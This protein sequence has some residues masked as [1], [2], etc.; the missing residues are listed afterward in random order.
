ME[1]PVGVMDSV[2]SQRLIDHHCHGVVRRDLSRVD[3]ERLL[4]E[5]D[6]P[7]PWH[8]SLFDTHVGLAIRRYCAPLL[9]LARHASP[10]DY[11]SRRTE[12]GHAEVARRMLSASGID[13][14][15]VDT[16]LTDDDLTTVAELA[17]LAGGR[18]RHVV[19][20]ERVAEQVVRTCTADEYADAFAVTLADAT[21]GA[22]AVKSI[23]AYR[24]GLDLRPDR[25]TPAEVARAAA[26]WRD[27]I[28]NGAG[29]RLTDETLIRH[30]IW[31]GLDGGRPLQLHVGYGDRDADLRRGDPLL[32]TPL[33][34]A[35][36]DAG[37][38]VMLLHTYPFHR[39]AGYLAQVYDHVFVDVGL[40]LHNV[41]PRGRVVL[42]ELLELAPFGSVLFSTDAY[43]LPELYAVGAT[44]FR[45]ALSAVLL[46]GLNAGYWS[47]PDADRF[48]G[49]IC[50]GNAERAYS[51]LP[52]AVSS[53]R[54]PP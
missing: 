2:R 54:P 1:Y 4:C 40:T 32:L 11:L 49:M 31:T 7:G 36:V 38:P 25:P 22:T 39:Q 3:F 23:A 24:C 5:A 12:L 51:L 10:E 42:A 46:T 43:G 26:R 44:M 20:L 33:L 18:G 45:Q 30:G 53:P 8:G 50:V 52:A 27:E 48:A 41:G 6:G 17:A 37:V 35:T 19:R 21:E 9:D 29:V 47:K 13:E 34:R 14:F 15:L 16:G 28:G